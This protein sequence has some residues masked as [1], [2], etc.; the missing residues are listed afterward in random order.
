MRKNFIKLSTGHLAGLLQQKGHEIRGKM[1]T[2][3]KQNWLWLRRGVRLKIMNACMLHYPVIYRRSG[4]G[5]RGA[6]DIAV[7]SMFHFFSS[8]SCLSSSSMSKI[9]CKLHRLRR[10]LSRSPVICTNELLPLLEPHCRTIFTNMSCNPYLF[11]Q[12]SKGALVRHIV[13]FFFLNMF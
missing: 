1:Y 10:S 8:S 5:M 3:L 12:K 11:L 6:L 4:F 7:R 13:L 2:F 9:T